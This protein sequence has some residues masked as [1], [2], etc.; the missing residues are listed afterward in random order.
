ML[1]ADGQ[2]DYPEHILGDLV[3]IFFKMVCLLIV[4]HDWKHLTIQI[5]EARRESDYGVKK[6]MTIILFQLDPQNRPFWNQRQEPGQ[7]QSFHFLLSV[8]RLSG[9][10]AAFSH[11]IMRRRGC[12]AVYWRLCGSTDTEN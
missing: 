2:T 1:S 3:G 9:K 5:S 10:I 7:F 4:R 8:M 6:H 12:Q 11:S